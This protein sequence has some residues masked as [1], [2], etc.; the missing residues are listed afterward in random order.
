MES[1]EDF[2][3]IYLSQLQKLNQVEKQEFIFKVLYEKYKNVLDEVEKLKQ[4]SELQ[5]TMRS[6]G[7]I[8]LKTFKFKKENLNAEYLNFAEI[9]KIDEEIKKE[10]LSFRI[11]VFLVNLTCTLD[12]FETEY[13]NEFI[14]LICE[15]TNFLLILKKFLPTVEEFEK[16]KRQ[17]EF[18]AKIQDV[19]T[20]KVEEEL[21]TI[22]NSQIIVSH[23]GVRI[24]Y[25]VDDGI[26]GSSFSSSLYVNL[27]AA[28][29][30]FINAFVF[31]RPDILL[32]F[33]PLKYIIW[34]TVI[35][36][37]L[38]TLLSLR[39]YNFRDHGVSL[40]KCLK[41]LLLVSSVNVFIPQQEQRLKNVLRNVLFNETSAE[42][43]L[44]I[45]IGAMIEVTVQ[46]FKIPAAKYPL[47]GVELMLLGYHFI[48]YN[49]DTMGFYRTIINIQDFE[50]DLKIIKEYQFPSGKPL[51]TYQ[52]WLY[53]LQ[54]TDD[55]AFII[56]G[57]AT[58]GVMNSAFKS[59][60]PMDFAKKGVIVSAAAGLGSLW[61]FTAVDQ[62]VQRQLKEF[63]GT[64]LNIAES[65]KSK[66]DKTFFQILEE[67]APGNI[68]LSDVEIKDPDLKVIFEKIN[69]IGN[70][71][72]TLSFGN[73]NYK[74]KKPLKETRKSLKEYKKNIEDATVN[75][76]LFNQK[77]KSLAWYFESQNL[78]ENKME[79]YEEIEEKMLYLSEVGD[80][81]RTLG[82][83]L[84]WNKE[85][86]GDYEF[87]IPHTRFT[88]FFIE[89]QERIPYLISNDP[90]YVSEYFKSV[91]H[92]FMKHMTMVY[93][94][95]VK[96]LYDFMEVFK[97][98][99]DFDIKKIFGEAMTS[100]G[101]NILNYI[102]LSVK[103]KFWFFFGSVIGGLFTSIM[104][105]CRLFKWNIS[106]QQLASYFNP[107]KYYWVNLTT[108]LLLP[109]ISLKAYVLL[110]VYEMSYLIRY[111]VLE[112]YPSLQ[113]EAEEVGFIL[114]VYDLA[115]KL[116][117]NLT[118][119]SDYM[120]NAKVSIG[121]PG[122]QN[123]KKVTVVSE[124][125]LK[126]IADDV[127]Y[128]NIKKKYK[129][130]NTFGILF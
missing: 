62:S 90:E 58:L 68:T 31:F 73:F 47:F 23:S 17:L 61:T 130:S 87:P 43:G 83:N 98:F 45:F 46:V 110:S 57:F 40:F 80:I 102:N 94:F 70:S 13:I 5:R 113:P 125:T 15:Y 30:S 21:Q 24:G 27:M 112:K 50:T 53:R 10:E 95:C 126:K 52:E 25:E 91:N 48:Y 71:T 49:D 1:E 33:I 63:E 82:I 18:F 88:E 106:F 11:Y 60:G 86:V 69:D 81:I 101:K 6:L 65:I 16:L 37:S 74:F 127:D 114:N 19:D 103:F 108:R 28:I 78:T 3:K 77:Q 35:I 32:D 122:E 117:L 84:A 115:K 39:E 34:S 4:R 54:K 119:L 128:K 109:N 104:A 123:K 8:N 76:L 20:K 51:G 96:Q 64:L 85:L 118:G 38:Q 121:Q 97:T 93:R 89:T 44:F 124:V 67:I 36:G 29:V 75:S 9:L 12:K 79:F 66:E 116:G 92:G 100:D 56:G 99:A 105:L 72:K 120:E 111:V 26:Q 41:G 129:R 2:K 22:K 7:N 14:S 42:V 55:A 107:L 59:S